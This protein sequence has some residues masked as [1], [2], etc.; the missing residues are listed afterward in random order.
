MTQNSK[1]LSDISFLKSDAA[2]LSGVGVHSGLISDISM[3]LR[4]LDAGNLK[5]D[6]EKNDLQ[7]S[8]SV[9]ECKYSNVFESNLCTAIS[10]AR[11][12]KIFTI[13]HLISAA[14]A[15]NCAFS[16]NLKGGEVPILDGSAMQF[17]NFLKSSFDCFCNRDDLKKDKKRINHFA[18]NLPILKIKREVIFQDDKRWVKFLPSDA[19]EFEITCDFAQKKIKSGTFSCVLDFDFYLKEI[20]PARTFGFVADLEKLNAA[21][22]AKG[23]SL[24][25]VIA[26][27][28]D[29]KCVNKEGMR[30]EDE[31]IRHKVLDAIGDVALS[32]YRVIGK[33]VGYCP[34]HAL[35][36]QLLR[37][38]FADASSFEVEGVQAGKLADLDAEVGECA[39]VFDG[40]RGVYNTFTLV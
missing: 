36:N 27:D 18:R 11:G 5:C 28:E 31:H 7:N 23:A 8:A 34:S 32:G 25:N 14:Y 19:Q 6:V 39:K 21:G 33:Y 3:N 17:V 38:V 10:N 9:L 20:A 13:E 35:N 37:A 16:F 12:D 40:A 2:S 22:L 30:F 4:G 1:C 26:F 29:G 15:F 24:D